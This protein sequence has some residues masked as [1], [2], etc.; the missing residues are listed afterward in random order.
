M[1]LYLPGSFRTSSVPAWLEEG[2][3]RSHQSKISLHACSRWSPLGP[4]AKDPPNC[5]NAKLFRQVDKLLQDT[6]QL[7]SVTA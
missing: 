5:R 3:V 2:A 6:R 4:E 7:T 1:L